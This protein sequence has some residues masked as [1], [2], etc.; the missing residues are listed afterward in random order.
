METFGQ[1]LRRLRGTRSLR[2]LAGLTSFSKS[3]LHDLETGRRS[4]YR[5]LVQALDEALGAGGQLLAAYRPDEHDNGPEVSPVLEETLRLWDDLL[6]RRDFL[7][8]T[9][10]TTA[11]TGLAAFPS[12]PGGGSER[13]A[14]HYELH[15]AIGRLGNLRGAPGSFELTLDHH[16][17][18]MTWYHATP[19]GAERSRI[20][21]LAS[22]TAGLVAFARFDIGQ[23]STAHRGFREAAGLAAEAGDISAA[24]NN[25]GQASRVMGVLGR[26]HDALNLADAAVR[27]A[28]SSAHPAVRS[29]L[30]AVRGYHHATVDHPDA[31]Y[32]DLD[33]AWS[34]L[35]QADDGAKPVYIGYLDASE[36]SKW[37]AHTRN[38]LGEPRPALAAA[39]DA[40][41]Q[42]PGIMVRGSAE[43]HVAAARAHLATKDL[44]QAITVLTHAATI[45]NST[46]SV[47]NFRTVTDVRARLSPYRDHRSVAE[48][49]EYLL[50][51]LGR[52]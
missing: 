29:W 22:T 26:H 8:T 23:Y 1:T 4:P 21:A 36:L 3:Y 37:S 32:A 44:D 10:A 52:P 13:L 11:A 41:A 48:F 16:D 31:A 49:D 51:G 24:A 14:A 40:Q 30:H 47:R 9:T 17:N 5:E 50:T 18:V 28:G 42:W 7:L 45:A 20:A 12:L 27:T 38:Q 33:A 46:G 34:L 2:S 25:I 19:P 15:E 6:R 43:L 35:P 39:T